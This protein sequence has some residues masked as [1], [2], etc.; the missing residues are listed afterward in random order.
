MRKHRYRVLNETDIEQLVEYIQKTESQAM[1][2]R[3]ELRK[4]KSTR[5]GRL[6]IALQECVNKPLNIHTW[7]QLPIKVLKSAFSKKPELERFV[8]KRHPILDQE[9]LES[10]L[11]TSNVNNTAVGAIFENTS[12]NLTLHQ[13]FVGIVNESTFARLG[14]EANVTYLRPDNYDYV[15]RQAAPTGFVF[16]PEVASLD[17][18]WCG[19]LS[20]DNVRATNLLVE[21]VKHMKR[22]GVVTFLVWSKEVERLNFYGEISTIFDYEIEV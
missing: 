22:S 11:N 2:A 20:S 21:C 14:I 19:V 12:L 3:N 5:L 15:L 7:S 17:P 10:L 6:A 4:Y 16:D 18:Y 1:W 13:N 8:K 9:K